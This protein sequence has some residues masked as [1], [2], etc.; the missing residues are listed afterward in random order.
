[1]L[2]GQIFLKNFSN[3]KSPENNAPEMT[4]TSVSYQTYRNC[5]YE[6]KLAKF[7]DSFDRL[8][9]TIASDFQSLRDDFKNSHAVYDDDDSTCSWYSYE[10]DR[11]TEP[12]S[13]NQQRCCQIFSGRFVDTENVGLGKQL[14]PPTDT[15]NESTTRDEIM[16]II[17]QSLPK[18][19]TC[20]P[21]NIKLADMVN[22]LM[23]KKDVDKSVKEQIKTV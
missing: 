8:S 18:D 23:H 7:A 10:V 3:L 16:N 12:Q 4:D 22:T 13:F 11:E 6:D 21:V 19:E 15:G 17:E 1:M 9:A 20:N 5:D 2:K 14:H